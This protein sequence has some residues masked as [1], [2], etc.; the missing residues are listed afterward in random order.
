MTGRGTGAIHSCNG[1][2]VEVAVER[3]GEDGTARGQVPDSATRCPADRT[4][5][6][7]WRAGIGHG[8]L[9]AA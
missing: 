5:A 1:Q 7:A 9:G 3:D 6:A 2:G 4:Q 8:R